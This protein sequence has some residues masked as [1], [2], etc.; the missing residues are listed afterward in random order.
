MA[1]KKKPARKS[2]RKA[3]KPTMAWGAYDR[4]GKL[5]FSTTCKLTARAWA[6][7][8]PEPARIARVRIVEVRR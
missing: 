2:P 8:E 3:A 7:T 5:L 4:R 6:A 1:T